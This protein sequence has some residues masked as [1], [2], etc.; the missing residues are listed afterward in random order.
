[1]Y[2]VSIGGRGGGTILKFNQDNEIGKI[3]GPLCAILKKKKCPKESKS[4]AELHE[5]I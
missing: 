4:S 3:S 5:A 1:M 2:A